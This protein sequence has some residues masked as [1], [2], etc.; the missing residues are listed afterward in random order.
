[1]TV[2]VLSLHVMMASIFVDRGQVARRLINLHQVVRHQA[3][4]QT[5]RLANV[6]TLT[7]CRRRDLRDVAHA[8]Y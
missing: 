2:D 1:M 6:E 5:Q 4:R 8:V 7:L 3:T